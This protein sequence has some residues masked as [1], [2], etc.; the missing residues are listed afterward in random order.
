MFMRAHT[1]PKEN[2]NGRKEQGE[3]KGV[4]GASG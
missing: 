1:G 4:F 3:N 2:G